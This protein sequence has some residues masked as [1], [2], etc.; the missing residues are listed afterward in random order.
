MFAS[1][2]MHWMRN[3]QK[4]LT[5]RVGTLRSWRTVP[6]Q[7]FSQCM[8]SATLFSQS[9]RNVSVELYDSKNPIQPIRTETNSSFGN[10][11]TV[12]CT[13]FLNELL[14]EQMKNIPNWVTSR[15]RIK[16]NF[17]HL[18]S[19]LHWRSAIHLSF[20]VTWQW[21]TSR[22]FQIISPQNKVYL[23]VRIQ[24]FRC[25]YPCSALKINNLFLSALKKSRNQS[26]TVLK[27]FE[28][29]PGCKR[30]TKWITRS[31]AD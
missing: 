8:K 5:L 21:C 16:T 22:L 31:E 4:T 15:H 14:N 18:S 25:P 12:T 26:A 3:F 20:P 24:L 7:R 30:A 17:L 13:I 2:W 27:D 19:K 28:W 6:L 23:G 11:I 29:N 9:F 10:S 1:A